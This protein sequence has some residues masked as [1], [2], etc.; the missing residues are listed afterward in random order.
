MQRTTLLAA[1]ALLV[2][3]AG[4]ALAA[5]GPADYAAAKALAK[6]ENKPLVLDFMTDW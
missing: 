3:G 1:L 4:A 2:L 6:A 5:D